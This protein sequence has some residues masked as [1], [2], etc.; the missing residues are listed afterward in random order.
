MRRGY[1][2]KNKGNLVGLGTRGDHRVMVTST[3]AASSSSS[4]FAHHT[5]STSSE[6]PKS[7]EDALIKHVM[8]TLEEI[9]TRTLDPAALGSRDALAK[10][11]YSRLFDWIV[12]KINNL[13]GHDPNSKSLIGVLDIYGFDSFKHNSGSTSAKLADVGSMWEGQNTST[14]CAMIRSKISQLLMMLRYGKGNCAEQIVEV[15]EAI[16]KLKSLEKVIEHRPVDFA[17]CF[18]A[19]ILRYLRARNWNVKK[20]V[21]MLEGSLIWRMSY[22]P[23]DIIWE[24]VAAEAEVGKIY[25]SN[26]KDKNGRVVLVLRPAFQVSSHFAECEYV[27][28]PF[29]AS[30]SYQLYS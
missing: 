21:K 5:G 9:I 6:Q 14:T 2:R 15:R 12:E 7:L 10:T 24:H 28:F 3:L 29:F 22:K 26:Y 25:R 4:S 18:D 27:I 20:A 23:E 1:R 30:M 8:V 11:V 19:S 17:S 16:K 13:I